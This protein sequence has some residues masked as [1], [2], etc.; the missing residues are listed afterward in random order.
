MEIA[1]TAL[2]T[3]M[4]RG[5]SLAEAMRNMAPGTLPFVFPATRALRYVGIFLF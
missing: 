2:L 5:A 1:V 4:A 3:D